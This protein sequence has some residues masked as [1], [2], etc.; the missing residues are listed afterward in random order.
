MATAPD[1]PQVHTPD[2]PAPTP[3]LLSNLG[4]THRTCPL[5]AAMDHAG[6]RAINAPARVFQ[7]R[8]C[9]PSL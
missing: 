4:T 6:D 2:R 5:L 1:M 7:A 8:A 3:P 9:F